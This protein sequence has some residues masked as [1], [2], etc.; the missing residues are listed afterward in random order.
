MPLPSGKLGRKKPE[1]VTVGE[2]RRN[3]EIDTPAT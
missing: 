2:V 3:L 1:G